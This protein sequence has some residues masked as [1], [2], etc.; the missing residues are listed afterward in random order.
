MSYTI[1][2][3]ENAIV[4]ALDVS[5]INGY[6]KTIEPYAG[7]LEQEVGKSLLIMPAVL[8]VFAGDTYS[9]ANAQNTQYNRTCDWDVLCAVRNLRGDVAA[10]QGAGSGATAEV[11]IYEMLDDVRAALVG[12]RLGLEIEPL[13]ILY[14]RRIVASAKAFIYA[15]RFQTQLD[16]VA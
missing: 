7:Q 2:T 4:A 15:V 13:R 12:N 10:L 6:A 16:Y 8:P 5:P 11:G 1:T 3:I 14:R 9:E